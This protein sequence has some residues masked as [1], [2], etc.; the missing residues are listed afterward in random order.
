MIRSYI[1][2]YLLVCTTYSVCA[3][4]TFGLNVAVDL[5]AGQTGKLEV[6]NQPSNYYAKCTLTPLDGDA[7]FQEWPVNIGYSY[8]SNDK[9]Y[10][11]AS[12][13]IFWAFINGRGISVVSGKIRVVCE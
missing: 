8:G 10:L 12:H 6:A 7:Y 4:S 11:P 3:M 13:S 2:V 1:V 5:S 9:Y